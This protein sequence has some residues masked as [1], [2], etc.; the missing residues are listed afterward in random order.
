MIEM[1]SNKLRITRSTI[2]K[3]SL[4]LV[5]E[6]LLRLEPFCELHLHV[7]LSFDTFSVFPLLLFVVVVVSVVVPIVGTVVESVP[8][9]GKGGE[10]CLE[11]NNELNGTSGITKSSSFTTICLFKTNAPTLIVSL[12]DFDVS[13]L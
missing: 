8:D 7:A 1:K 11:L 10:F 12:N 9:V 2:M 3:S 4:A 6:Q 5:I 13:S